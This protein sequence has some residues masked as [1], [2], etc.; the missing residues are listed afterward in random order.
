MGVVVFADNDVILKLSEYN[1]LREACDALAVEPA[2]V[3]VLNTA[4]HY[5]TRMRDKATG[6][7]A[8]HYS[9]E[10]LDRAIGFAESA[11]RVEEYPN[12]DWAVGLDDVDLGEAQLATWAADTSD[13]CLLV[14]GDKRF[15]KALVLH[16]EGPAS[17][18][19]RRIA[20]RVVC[21]E[22]LV[23]VLIARI[24]FQPVRAAVARCPGCDQSASIVFGSRFDLPVEQVVDGLESIIRDVARDA[25]EGWLRRLQPS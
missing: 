14:S 11:H 7:K 6:G 18:V 10:G 16:K 25:G 22:E 13:D 3:V 23:R 24:G 20:G 1:L 4:Q 12:L 17:R 21:F 19:F 9:L 15:I 2:Q 8:A 5:F